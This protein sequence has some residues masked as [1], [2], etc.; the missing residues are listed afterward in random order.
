MHEAISNI[1]LNAR[2]TGYALCGVLLLFS[3]FLWAG[4]L[5]IFPVRLV[6]CSH[7]QICKQVEHYW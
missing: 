1:L 2:D 5:N 6:F 7:M 3:G 4:L